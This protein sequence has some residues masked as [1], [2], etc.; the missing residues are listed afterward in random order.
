[1]LGAGPGTLR[2]HFRNTKATS[3]E[4][5]RGIGLLRG[6]PSTPR[7]QTNVGNNEAHIGADTEVRSAEATGNKESVHHS[8]SAFAQSQVT[9]LKT[10][11]HFFITDT[12]LDVMI[13]E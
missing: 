1:L 2:N 8:H 5:N 6:N 11:C 10:A 9:L 13:K 12:L 7:P 3:Q 4:K